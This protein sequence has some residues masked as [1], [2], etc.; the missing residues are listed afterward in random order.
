MTTGDPCPDGFLALRDEASSAFRSPLGPAAGRP[1]P[2]PV[3]LIA[4]ARAGSPDALGE[5]YDRYAAG[6][7]T[8]AARLLGSTAD[9]EDVV[10][11]VFLGLAETLRSFEGRGNF[12]GWLGRVCTRAALMK[13]RRA[14]VEARA[15]AAGNADR[16]PEAVGNAWIDRIVLETA[17][18]QLP[19]PLRTVFVLKEFAGYSH[20]EIAE[21]EE[22][23]VANSKARLFR[24]RERL[25]DLLEDAR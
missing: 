5:L 24:A 20:A 19:R 1:P 3:D 10:H 17:I 11:D 13:L 21:M 22:I 15:V 23:S 7:Y 9:A 4:G 6:I 2:N 18:A 25:R 8:I 12:A 14:K 16:R